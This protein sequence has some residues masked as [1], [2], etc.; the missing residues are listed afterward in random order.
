MV[1]IFQIEVILF[2]LF[3]LS[4]VISRF[5]DKQISVPELAFWSLLWIA[6]AV[7]LFVPQI[8]EPIARMLDIGRG[9]DVAVY[10]SIVLLLYLVFRLY[11]KI[12]MMNQELT[13]VVR[14]I[15]MNKKR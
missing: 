10:L 14:E 15:S 4:R 12:D 7:V 13:A 2:V 11:A 8:T 5:R 9:I 6:V 1:S 3:A